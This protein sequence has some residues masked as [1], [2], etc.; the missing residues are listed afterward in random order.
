MLALTHL[1]MPPL[2]ANE[3]SLHE[4]SIFTSETETR[5]MHSRAR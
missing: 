2:Y 1:I 4:Y 3:V 5:H